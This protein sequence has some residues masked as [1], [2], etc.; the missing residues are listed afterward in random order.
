MRPDCDNQVSVSP[1]VWGF[2][3]GFACGF[4][5]VVLGLIVAAVLMH[6]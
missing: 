6:L 4:G 3:T 2:V 5:Y 1:W